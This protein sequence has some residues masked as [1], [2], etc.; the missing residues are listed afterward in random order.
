MK[1]PVFSVAYAPESV[2]WTIYKD[3]HHA[4]STM[5]VV[6]IVWL[7]IITVLSMLSI[8]GKCSE[9]STILINPRAKYARSN[10]NHSRAFFYSNGIIMTHTPRAFFEPGGILEILCFNL[11]E[12]VLGYPELVS[13]LLL[14]FHIRRHH[15]EAT[16]THMPQFLPFTS[17]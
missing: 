13:N 7:V 11:I 17:C 15:H 8:G 6:P 3:C 1:P 10:A 2:L 9:D 5:A 12:Q 16:D 14:V 4:G